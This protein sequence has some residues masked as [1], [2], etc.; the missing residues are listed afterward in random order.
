LGI[1]SGV[2]EDEYYEWFHAC[3]F[4]RTGHGTLTTE[5]MINAAGKIIHVPRPSELSPADR[6]EATQG[7]SKYFGWSSRWGV[8]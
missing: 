1:D 5:D 7:M 4:E 2:T 3:G 8:H 6:V